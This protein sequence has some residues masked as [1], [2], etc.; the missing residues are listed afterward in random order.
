MTPVYGA[1]RT[2]HGQIS[3]V[4]SEYAYR[5]YNVEV[6]RGFEVLVDVTEVQYHAQGSRLLFGPLTL[7]VMMEP[8]ILDHGLLADHASL[9]AEEVRNDA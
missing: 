8:R 1:P 4:S 9:I 5:K 3:G 2:I 6:R 7:V